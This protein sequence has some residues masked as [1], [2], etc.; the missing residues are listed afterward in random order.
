MALK[1]SRDRRK[2]APIL[3]LSVSFRGK[4]KI[5]E[6]M[7]RTTKIITPM[8]VRASMAPLISVPENAMRLSGSSDPDVRPLMSMP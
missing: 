7:K 8:L 2:V 4:V 3:T 5:S 1:L 6:I